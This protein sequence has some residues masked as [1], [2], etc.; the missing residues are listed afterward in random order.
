M[1]QNL[2]GALKTLHT[3]AVDAREGYEEALKDAEGKGLTPLFRQMI[4]M[5]R[6]NDTEL[7]AKLRGLGEAADPDGSSMAVLHRTIMSIRALFGGLDESILPGLVDGEQR[8]VSHYDDAL[9]LTDTPADTRALLEAQ[10][11]RIASAIAGM[12]AREH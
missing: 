1:T 10:R 2:I 7:A 9:K 3:N 6:L 4:A 5:H 12:Q 8:N 11:A